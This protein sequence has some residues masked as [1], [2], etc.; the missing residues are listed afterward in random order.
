MKK[1]SRFWYGV[2]VVTPGLLVGIPQNIIGLCT[3]GY[4][5]PAWDIEVMYRL[6][7]YFQRRMR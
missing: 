7:L 2:L 4:W 5:V 1:V 3:L 6:G